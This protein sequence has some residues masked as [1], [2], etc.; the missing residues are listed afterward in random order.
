MLRASNSLLS[1][2]SRIPFSMTGAII[3]LNFSVFAVMGFPTHAVGASHLLTWGA[4][5]GALSLDGQLWRVL[6]AMFVHDGLEHVLVNMFGLLVA[7]KRE[8][9]AFGPWPFLSLYLLSGL[10][11]AIATLAIRP[12]LYNC[13]ASGGVFGV[14]GA[15]IAARWT[16]RLPPNAQKRNPLSLVVLVIFVAGSLYAGATDPHVN[17]V[18]HVGGL[19][20]GVLVGLLLSRTGASVWHRTWVVVSG[21][22]FLV[23]AMY[24]VRYHNG[25]VVSLETGRRAMAAARLDEAA[26]NYTAVRHAHPTDVSANLAMGDICLM[27]TAD[28]FADAYLN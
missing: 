4:S 15:L 1:R 18:A 3:L 14:I 26:W 13:G 12:E 16:R 24:L 11:G 7:G 5:W 28:I 8:E 10:V 23:V 21:M 19:L 17:N 9:P 20:A 22:M 6:T 2:L 27:K 25:W